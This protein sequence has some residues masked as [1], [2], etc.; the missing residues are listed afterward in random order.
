MGVKREVKMGVKREVKMGVKR[1]VKLGVKREVKM[2]VK[3]EVNDSFANE[4]RYYKDKEQTE[5]LN[6]QMV[7]LWFASHWCVRDDH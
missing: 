6:N 2:G 4:N 3:R 7:R 5:L 1:E